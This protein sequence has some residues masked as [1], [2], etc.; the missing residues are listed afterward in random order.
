MIP[1]KIIIARPT[2]SKYEVKLPN[3]EVIVLSKGKPSYVS[4]D[5][6]VLEFC[7]KQ[8]GLAVTD[9]PTREFITYAKKELSDK[10]I[11]Q[12]R[13]VKLEDVLD[14]KWSSREEELAVAKLKSLGYICYPKKTKKD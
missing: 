6:E 12:N 7:A 14:K 5:P 8:K 2:I 13:A 1:K 9:L 11:I 10:P 3:G 4:S